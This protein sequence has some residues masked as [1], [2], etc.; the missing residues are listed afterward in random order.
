MRAIRSGFRRAAGVAV[1]VLAVGIGAC[2]EESPLEPVL[3]LELM[4]GIYD[5]TTLTFDPQGSAPLADVLPVIQTT[6][7]P[8]LNV[9]AVTETFQIFYYDPTTQRVET[10]EGGVEA[11]ATGLRM[12]F[13]SQQDANQLLLP[14]TLELEFDEQRG[15]LSFQGNASV[16]RQRLL[17]LFPERYADEQLFDPTPG[18]LTVQFNERQQAQ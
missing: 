4:A 2:D 16:S 9:S 11:T 18:T 7:D 5:P 17:Q 15:V 14:T 10:L 3:D 1:A 13:T 12:T 8:Q 6:L